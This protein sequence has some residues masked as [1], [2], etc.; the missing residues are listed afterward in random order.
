MPEVA[1]GSRS[2][3]NS[4]LVWHPKFSVN[5][6]DQI[7]LLLLSRA[8]SVEQPIFLPD[9]AF[10]KFACFEQPC[11]LSELIELDAEFASPDVFYVIQQLLDADILVE[12]EQAALDYISAENIN[13][14]TA[15]VDNITSHSRQIT[16]TLLTQFH[17]E[18]YKN[19]VDGADFESL[20]VIFIDDFLLLNQK[21]VD[22]ENTIFV[23]VSAD[24]VL[25]FPRLDRQGDEYLNRL[26]H[27]ILKNQ[28]MRYALSQ[29]KNSDQAAS[30]PVKRLA[31]NQSHIDPIAELV[32]EQARDELSSLRKLVEISVEDL[33]VK[34]HPITLTVF[35]EDALATGKNHSAIKLQSV[36]GLNS[37]EGGT[38]VV[39]AG[40]T[41]ESLKSLVSPITGVINQ[42]YELPTQYH[43]NI[44]IFQSG[45]FKIPKLSSLTN[46]QAIHQE[47]QQVCLGKGVSVTQ[48]KVSALSEA[49]ERRNAVFDQSLN[50][51]SARVSDLKA[52]EQ[53]YYEYQD[54]VPYS[55]AQYRDFTDP[56]NS[57][58]KRKQAVIKYNDETIQW[59]ENWSLSHNEIVYLPLTACQ[60]QTGFDQEKFGRW[61]SNGCSAGNCLEE[62]ILQGLFEL[63]ERDAT[64]I[65]WYNKI[66]FPA[67]D[68]TLLKPSDFERFNES[69]HVHYDYWVLDLTNDVGVPVMGA[70]A[71]H[72]V[73][74]GFVM[75]FG[76]HLKPVLAAQ[77]ALSELCQLI[78]IRDQHSA[79]FDF[80]KM[81]EESYL[82]PCLEKST[83]EYLECNSHIL[84]DNIEKI[85]HRLLTLDLETLVFDYSKSDTPLSTVKV[86]VPGLCH[87]WPQ[88]GNKRLYDVPVKLGWKSSAFSE[89][90]LNAQALYI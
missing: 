63:I 25:I 11:V 45:F 84:K 78:P 57:E 85:V 9:H 23:Q 49:I 34:Y 47:L 18:F 54:L 36:E 77:R 27:R 21:K 8:G 15:S 39:A 28:P 43:D 30:V 59:V 22:V 41:Y 87:I 44:K 48:S 64:S 17:N 83:T 19:C 69:L 76:A 29:Y 40:E 75:G 6:I 68:L 67:F 10:S 20:K 37:A 86:T 70:I 80:D 74:G 73:S 13:V 16:A 82:F 89:S 35:Q 2:I 31:L 52:M 53:R 56:L 33:A 3:L 66:N 61:H 26:K 24:E 4:R 60:A 1:S 55:D 42:F 14:H 51:L 50:C 58:S 7:G 65:W 79:P 71:Q 62:A 12:S 90:E 38:R 32:F 46:S 88:Y 72:R 81:E 5:Y